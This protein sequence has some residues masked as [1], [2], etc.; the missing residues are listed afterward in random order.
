MA[1]AGIQNNGAGTDDRAVF[2]VSSARYLV[3]LVAH[4]YPKQAS[5]PKIDCV[6]PVAIP[7]LSFDRFMKKL[8]TSATTL[9]RKLR[10]DLHQYRRLARDARSKG[11]VK[12]AEL[13]SNIV[14]A[15]R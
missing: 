15:N 7:Y 6:Q 2:P 10:E 9:H 14:E 3:R 4:A 1:L 12:Q 11:L 13:W 5:L 8:A